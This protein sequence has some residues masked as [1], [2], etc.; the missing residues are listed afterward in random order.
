MSCENFDYSRECP[1]IDIKICDHSSVLNEIVELRKFSNSLDERMRKLKIPNFSDDIEILGK[2]E[3]EI[4]SILT[5]RLVEMKK[6]KKMH[7]KIFD[8]LEGKISKYQRKLLGIEKCLDKNEK[9]IEQKI[10]NFANVEEKMKKR[11]DKISNKTRSEWDDLMEIMRKYERVSK[12]L[13]DLKITLGGLQEKVNDTVNETEMIEKEIYKTQVRLIKE[14]EIKENLNNLESNFITS[15]ENFNIE[16]SYLQDLSANL[17]EVIHEICEEK[18][19]MQK[20]LNE[21]QEDDEIN[22]RI[23]NPWK[24]QVSLSIHSTLANYRKRS[25]FQ[26]CLIDE[27]LIQ[28]TE[29]RRKIENY[30]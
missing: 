16:Y 7:C 24:D 5:D 8:F 11:I 22:N 9:L 21:I 29:L 30:E 14:N 4:L 3:C 1:T 6:I 18:E 17:I 19:N 26:D 23:M 25:D 15:S 10:E 12:K 27:F 20:V 2:S 28:I 13:L